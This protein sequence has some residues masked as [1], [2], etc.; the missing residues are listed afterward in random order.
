MQARV[1]GRWSSFG[2]G[3]LVSCVPS[4]PTRPSVSATA[5]DGSVGLSWAEVP[6][7]ERYAVAWRRSGDSSWRTSTYDCRGGSYT[8]TGLSNGTAY[9]FVV[10]A[11]FPGRWSDFG[12]GDV[13][14]ATTKGTPIMGSAMT[15]VDRMVSV[16]ESSGATYPSSVYVSKGAASIRSFCMIVYNEATAEGVR[17]E[18]L[19]AQAMLETGWLMFGGDVSPDQCNFGGLGAVGNGAS[20]LTFSDVTTGLR[21]QVQHLKAYASTDPLRLECVDPRFRYV[22]RGCAPCVEDLTGR[23]AAGHNYAASIV[24]IINCLI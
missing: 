21:A 22:M 4:G 11:R 2:E 24:S 3:N 17:P 7:A 15:T 9:E 18:V 16:Y 12:P 23:W 20:G 8:V 1:A 19:F 13:V 5:S 10:Q 14:S 6:G